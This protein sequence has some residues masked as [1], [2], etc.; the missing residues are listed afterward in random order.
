MLTF[1]TQFPID[2]NMNIEDII[3]A[4]RIWLAGSPHS[5]LAKILSNEKHITDGCKFTAENETITFHQYSDGEELGAFRHENLDTSGTHWITEVSAAKLNNHFWISIQLSAD[6]E[7]PVEKVEFG[8]RPYIL[9]TI[10]TKIGGGYD[11]LLPV[12]DK[13]YYL[14]ED[15][16]NLAA[17]LITANADCVMPVVYV[18]VNDKNETH[19]NTK[20]LAQWLS[21]M[22]HVVVE[23][24][25]GFSFELMHHVYNENAYGG[26]VAI[27]WPDGIGKWLFL[28]KGEH[29]QPQNMQKSISYK[30]RNSLLSQRTKRECRWGYVQERIFKAK[31][32]ELKDSGSE[33]VDDYV[34]LFDKELIAKDEEIQ[35]LESE[36][37]RLK[38]GGYDGQEEK[39]N[40]NTIVLNGAENDLYQAERLAI[41]IDALSAARDAAEAYSRRKDVL[42][43]LIEQNSQDG[44]RETILAAMKSMLKSYKSMSSSDRRTLENIGFSITEEGKHYKLTFRDD[45][46]YSFTLSKTGSDFRGG[47]NAFSD[48]RRRMF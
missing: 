2:K 4:G 26:A 1:K 28:P 40:N 44:E 42:V 9:K 35:R 34:A 22:A 32:E 10:M 41:I 39:T 24:T 47:L 30:V 19:I 11:G 38:Y 36:I 45:Q 12:S 8:K 31:L 48:L 16:I 6:S 27:Y 5:K 20:Q 7:L 14:S 13:P 46:R 15:E 17:D 3:E 18:S 37:N 33:K 29:A 43:D 23:P 25:R 21:G